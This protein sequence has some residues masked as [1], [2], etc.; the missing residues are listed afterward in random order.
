MIYRLF[1]EENCCA[2]LRLILPHKTFGIYY[3]DNAKI[4]MP[5][6]DAV[7]NAELKTLRKIATNN[8]LNAAHQAKVLNFSFS[9]P[10]IMP[11]EM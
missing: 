6:T 5:S 4:Y 11:I 7:L 3:F 9:L 2:V 8:G 10:L 1:F